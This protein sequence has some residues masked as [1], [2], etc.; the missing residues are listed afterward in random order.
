M[1]LLP[2]YGEDSLADLMPSVLAALGVR[3][4]HDILGLPPSSRYCVVLV[5][6]LGW[7]QLRS[8]PREAPFLASLPGR[9]IT[10]G[11]PTTTATSLTS[12]GTGLPPGRHGVVGYTSRVPGTKDELFHSLKWEPDL[13][14]LA[15]QPYSSVFERAVRAGVAATVVGQRRFNGTGLTRVAF[16]GPFRAANTY[17]ERVAAA[18]TALEGADPALV[19]I[20]EG[21]LDYTGHQAGVASAAW[22][23]QLTMVD[24]FL[25]E[26]HDA[27]PPGATMVVTADHGMVDVASSQR[28]DV[29]HVPALRDGVALVAGEARFRHVYA[30]DGAAA[31]VEAAW[32]A[33]LGE[34]AVVRSRAAAVSEGWFGAVDARV[35]ERIGDVVVNVAGD[36]AIE[37]RSVFPAEPKLIGLHGAIT[38][39][40]LF[41]PLL[42]T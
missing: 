28:I 13:D 33:V 15:Y 32:R 11:V 22:R 12:L 9:A 16:R 23:Y 2:R 35:A 42:T 8:H 1:T 3:G 39:D 20:Y 10:V 31:D 24:R 29:D 25:E 37:R 41:V 7:R 14:P 30:V 4:E 38:D 36:C 19:Y 34:R 18:V 26:L 27:L 40:E 6:G 17:G 21:D 5:D